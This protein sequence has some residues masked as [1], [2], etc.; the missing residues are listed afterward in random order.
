MDPGSNLVPP[1]EPAHVLGAGFL[2]K[3][4]E[5]ALIRELSSGGV[6]AKAQVFFAFCY[7]GTIC[8]RIRSRSGG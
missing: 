1:S 6:R 2:Q 3:V 5:R 7:K 4:Y 8:R